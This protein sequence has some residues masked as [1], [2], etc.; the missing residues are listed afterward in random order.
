MQGSGRLMRKFASF[1]VIAASVI[2]AALTAANAAE[3]PKVLNADGLSAY[4]EVSAVGVQ[5]YVCSKKDPAA[6]AW[7]F[8]APEATLSDVKQKPFGKH[9]AGPTWEGLDGSKV[10]GAVRASL[11]GATASDIPWLR[12][13]VK[14]REGTGVLTAA[15]GIVR[16][17][18]AGGVAPAQGCDEGHSGAEVRVPYTA[19]YLFLK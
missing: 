15:S 18:T 16:M 9:Y 8:K 12:L 13:D 7:V 17:S 10:V 3:V 6:W 14:S 2:W 11:P 4:L 5:I 19:R 1:C